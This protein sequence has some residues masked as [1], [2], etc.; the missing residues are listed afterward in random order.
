MGPVILP[1]EIWVKIRSSGVLT[2]M[3]ASAKELLMS[4]ITCTGERGKRGKDGD[5]DHASQKRAR[6]TL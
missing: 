3:T 1:D 2:T 6:L 5:D 4:R